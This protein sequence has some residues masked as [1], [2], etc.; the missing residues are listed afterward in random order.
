[1]P[2][3]IEELAWADE[4]VPFGIVVKAGVA[5]WPKGLAI[6]E[7]PFVAGAGDWPKG[8]VVVAAAVCPAG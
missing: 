5:V 7:N 4:L 1:M 8:L 6:V 2:L 3:A